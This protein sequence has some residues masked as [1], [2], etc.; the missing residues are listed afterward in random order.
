LKRP[1]AFALALAALLVALP[2]VLL[3]EHGEEKGPLVLAASSLQESLEAAADAWVQKGHP[4][5]V[6][7]FAAT[8]ALARQVE[9]GAPADIIISADEEWMNELALKGLIHNRLRGNLAGNDLVLV[10]QA[11]KDTKLELQPGA[12]LAFVLNPQRVA[13]ADPQSVPAGRYARQAL[14][15]LGV[16]SVVEKNV[17]SADNV[18]AA[19]ALVSHGEVPF[20]IVYKTDALADPKLRIVATFPASSHVPIIYPVA[21]L[22]TSVNPDAEPFRQFLLS[23]E[24]ATIFRRYGFSTGAQR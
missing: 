18:R 13:L 17:V 15:K 10:E 6:L 2:F 9:A 20:G 11:G 21:L 19:A 5:P 22:K 24:A 16:W 23:D 8:P 1:L 7:S 4:R 12:A 14:T 3:N